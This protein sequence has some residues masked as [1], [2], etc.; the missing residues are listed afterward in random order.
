M[1]VMEFDSQTVRFARAHHKHT[2]DAS[3]VGYDPTFRQ[4]I[5]MVENRFDV[6]LGPVPS[7]EQTTEMRKVVNPSR[8][9]PQFAEIAFGGKTAVAHH[10]YNGS[11]TA[12]LAD[13][14]SNYE[15]A[16]EE[17]RAHYNDDSTHPV[18]DENQGNKSEAYIHLS[19]LSSMVP[20]WV[21]L[22]AEEAFISTIEEVSDPG[23]KADIEGKVDFEI[24]GVGDGQLKKATKKYRP[25]SFDNDGEPW[26]ILVKWHEYDGKF[27]YGVEPIRPGGHESSSDNWDEWKAY[28]VLKEK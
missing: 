1:G 23:L 11:L 7:R 16:V 18:I 17:L 28:D 5:T 27:V 21:G 22:T 12:Y 4:C 2:V 9:G 25:S 8:G 15:Q 20:T 6:E 24:D 3:R 10:N 19:I 14:W 13:N 26:D